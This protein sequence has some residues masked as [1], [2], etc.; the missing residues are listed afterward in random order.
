M[1]RTLVSPGSLEWKINGVNNKIL[2]KECTLSDPFY[3][4]LYKFQAKIRWDKIENDVGL[5]LCIMKGEW[6]DALKWP[7]RYKYPLV[8]IN[9]LDAS[10]NYERNYEIT[11]EDLVKFPHCFNKPS[12]KRT[13]GFGSDDFISQ[14]DLL[15]EKYSKD[16]KI[17]LKIS[18]E[19][20]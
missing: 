18:V 4:G 12:T 16:D 13:I 5:F 2:Q 15:E 20:F 11:V 10:D 9:Q 3:V 17:T 14:A 6:D 7:I 8:I 1:M 19:L